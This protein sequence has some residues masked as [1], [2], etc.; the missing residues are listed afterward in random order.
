MGT[1]SV[2][3][4]VLSLDDGK[5]GRCRTK[6]SQHIRKAA[7]IRPPRLRVWDKGGAEST[8]RENGEPSGRATELCGISSTRFGAVGQRGPG[9]R[10]L[11]CRVAVCGGSRRAAPGPRDV[12][13]SLYPTQYVEGHGNR[14]E[15]SL[16]ELHSS[17]DIAAC[18]TERDAGL[19]GQV[20]GDHCAGGQG[21]CNGDIRET[22]R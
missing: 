20:G 21:T 15:N 6:S 18:I 2:R 17:K 14:Y 3:L 9:T 12:Q 11:D 16:P 8:A 5:H 13:H 22:S 7:L 10:D 1:G 19:D 4:A